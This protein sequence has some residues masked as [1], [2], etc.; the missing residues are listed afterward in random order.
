MESIVKEIINLIKSRWHKKSTILILVLFSS[1]V[2][3]WVFSGINFQNIKESQLW[4]GGLLLTFLVVYWYYS[5][6][7]PRAPKGKIGFALGIVADN[8]AQQQKLKR[9]FSQT[10]RDLLNRSKY[11]YSF[12]FVEIPNHFIDKIVS[13]DDAIKT[14]HNSRSSFMVYGKARTITINGQLQHILNLEGVVAHKPIPTEISK[15]FSK[16]FSDL[17]PRRMTISSEGDL[18]Q[19]EVTAQW[20]D[21]VSKYIIGVAALLSGDI[22]YAQ[23]L[24]ENL[25]QVFLDKKSSLPAFIKIKQRL[26]S[27]LEDI[28]LIQ[29]NILYEELKHTK[30]DTLMSKMKPVLDKLSIVSPNSF[31]ARFFRSVWYF[32]HSRNVSKAKAETLKAQN[33]KHTTWQY[34]YAFLLA[35][36]GNMREAVRQYKFAVEEVFEEPKVVL[37]VIEFIM[38]V[39]DVE[40]DKTQLHFCLGMIYYY[41]I[42][43]Y[44]LALQDFE[45]F[46][47]VTPVNRFSSQ[48]REAERLITQIKKDIKSGKI[49]FEN[50]VDV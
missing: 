5:N 1:G 48:R 7:L 29:L 46:V 25:Q 18:F 26:P 21:V 14:L 34:N 24:F 32:L 44:A 38:W 19:F 8:P 12:V 45:K 31:D 30:A 40:P 47:E 49:K 37:E 13:P 11:K 22:G 17:F 4:V 43:D 33:K 27:R 3:L 20:I 41:A 39:L 15:S 9:D 16:E 36:E 28:Y 6:R 10:L 50:E 35:Y 23:E 42:K 2:L